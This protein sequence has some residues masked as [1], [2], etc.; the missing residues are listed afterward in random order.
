MIFKVYNEVSG[1]WVYYDNLD[2]IEVTD[3]RIV[4]VPHRETAR[5]ASETGCTAVFEMKETR[6]SHLEVQYEDGGLVPYT[7]S[8]ITF[9]AGSW[10]RLATLTHRVLN[11]TV[12]QI[13]YRTAYLLNDAGKTVEVLTKARLAI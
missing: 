5:P 11:E 9:E 6:T 3:C 2:K 12:S 7:D 8:F 4:E 1:S 10:A 13:V